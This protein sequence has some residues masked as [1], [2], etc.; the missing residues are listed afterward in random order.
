MHKM[1]DRKYRVS[2]IWYDT[3]F[4]SIALNVDESISE[5]FKQSAL[6]S[7]LQ[8]KSVFYE[9]PSSEY[10]YHYGVI[11]SSSDPEITVWNTK[12]HTFVFHHSFLP[13]VK[14]FLMNVPLYEI[15]KRYLRN[16]KELYNIK[17]CTSG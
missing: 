1:V 3:G 17:L 5:T 2:V 10:T 11:C 13:Y 4:I 15:Y 6:L 8:K 7:F 14:C 9:P 16:K 12:L